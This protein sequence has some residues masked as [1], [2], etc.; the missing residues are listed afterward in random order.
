VTLELVFPAFGTFLP[1]D[2]AYPLYGALS[3]IVPTFH[4]EESP[5]RFAPNTGRATPDGLLH[6]TEHSQLR[7]QLTCGS[8]A[9]SRSHG[10]T[11]NGVRL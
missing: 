5:L 2:H 3:G 8:A 6:L 7:V 1:T 4:D 9:T 10:S 11:S